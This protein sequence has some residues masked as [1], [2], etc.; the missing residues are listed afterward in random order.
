MADTPLPRPAGLL[1]R[2]GAMLYDAMIVLALWLLTL[3][4]GVALHNGAVVGPLVQTIL[5]VELF[6]FFAYFWVWRGQTIGMLAWHLHV[7]TSDGTPM[8]L[9]QALLR[10]IGAMLSFTTLGIGYLWMYVDPDRRAWPDMLS[11]THIVHRPPQ[12]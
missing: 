11:R 8:R 1:R 4:I 7:E 6:S 10:F 2:L 3:F 5:F 9:G 12:A